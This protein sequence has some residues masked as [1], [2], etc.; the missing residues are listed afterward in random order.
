VVVIVR[1][2]HW[3]GITS[4]AGRALVELVGAARVVEVVTGDVVTGEVVETPA[5]GAHPATSSVIARTA[6]LR[7]VAS[8]RC[9]ARV[10]TDPNKGPWSMVDGRWPEKSIA[11]S[12]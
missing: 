6:I 10:T 1:P 3:G 7:T 5:S 12:R 9:R 8:P 4:P 2:S 11:D